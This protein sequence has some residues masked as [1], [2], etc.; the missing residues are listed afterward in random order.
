MAQGV[1]DSDEARSVAGRT[2]PGSLIG[3]ELGR[4]ERDSLPRMDSELLAAGIGPGHPSL[5]VSPDTDEPESAPD[6]QHVDHDHDHDHHDHHHDE[7]EHHPLHQ[8]QH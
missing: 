4:G 7:H 5:F 3:E 6:Q 2:G 8:H 1:A